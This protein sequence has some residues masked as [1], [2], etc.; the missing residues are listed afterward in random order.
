M[1]I[2]QLG[3]SLLLLFI[4]DGVAAKNDTLD[5]AASDPKK[6][7]LMQ[8]FPPPPDKLVTMATSNTFR[9]L[10]PKAIMVMRSIIKRSTQ[11]PLAG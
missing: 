5:A 10:N 3:F 11:T 2:L 1:H 7:G 9:L 6:L 8:G 4:S